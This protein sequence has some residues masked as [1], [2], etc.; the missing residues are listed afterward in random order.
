MYFFDGRRAAGLAHG[1]TKIGLNATLLRENE[2]DMLAQTVPH[3]LAHV[4]VYRRFLRAGTRGA[5]WVRPR[6]HG[7]EW[8]AVMRRIF[9][10]DPARCHSY[11]ISNV[12]A[13]TYRVMPYACQ[14]GQ[15]HSLTRRVHAEVQAGRHRRCTVCKSRIVWVGGES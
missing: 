14:C 12:R 10:R 15:I 13:R 5:A 11:D 9:D 6:P 4:I 8:Q 3:E 7:D 2:A 1:D